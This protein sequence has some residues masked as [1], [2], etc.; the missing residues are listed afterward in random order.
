MTDNHSYN[1]PGLGTTDWHL[2]LNQNFERLDTGVEIRD[3]EANLSEYTPKS[4]AKFLSTDTKRVF[5]GDGSEWRYF[6]TLGGIE[7]R[8]YVQA[9]TPEGSEGDLWIRTAGET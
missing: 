3:V 8:I 5:L 2:P 4:G 9:E 6:T 1:T 7:G